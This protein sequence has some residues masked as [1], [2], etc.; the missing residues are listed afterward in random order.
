MYKTM[1]Q[2]SGRILKGELYTIFL[3]R[4]KRDNH[5]DKKK[6]EIYHQ[7]QKHG[8]KV[9]IYAQICMEL[10]SDLIHFSV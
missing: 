8:S 7:N 10:P 1:S 4:Q 2:K 6:T 9:I 5:L 3:L